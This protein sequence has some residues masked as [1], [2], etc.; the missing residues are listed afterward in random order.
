MP[1]TTE[2]PKYRDGE[3]GNSEG[4]VVKQFRVKVVEVCPA[5]LKTHNI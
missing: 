4:E 3:F 5:P 2:S 1:C